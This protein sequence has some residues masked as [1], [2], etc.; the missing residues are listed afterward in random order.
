MAATKGT[1]SLLAFFP[2]VIESCAY[3]TL[4][5]GVTVTHTLK[6]QINVKPFKVELQVD[7]RATSRDP[8]FL[9]VDDSAYVSTDGANTIALQFD[10]IPGG[11]LTGAEVRVLIYHLAQASGGISA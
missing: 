2:H 7:E 6:N 11:D 9:V 5:P 4:V 8:V 10:T 3:T 1:P